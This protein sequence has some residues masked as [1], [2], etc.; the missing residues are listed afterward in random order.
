MTR[1]NLSSAADMRAKDHAVA[2]AH[3]RG[4]QRVAKLGEYRGLPPCST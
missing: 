2:R 3:R 1:H 4:W